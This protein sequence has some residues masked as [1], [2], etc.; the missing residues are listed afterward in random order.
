MAV[1]VLC[2]NLKPGSQFEFLLAGATRVGIV[3]SAKVVPH[4]KGNEPS[5]VR[6]VFDMVDGPAGCVTA[7]RNRTHIPLHQQDLRSNPNVQA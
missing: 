5:Q 2:N 1:E 4:P 7:F 6:V 3:R